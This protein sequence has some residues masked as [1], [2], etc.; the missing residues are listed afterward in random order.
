MAFIAA[1]NMPVCKYLRGSLV[2]CIPHEYIGGA[3]WTFKYAHAINYP[4][5]RMVE[6]SLTL[7]LNYFM[8]ITSAELLINARKLDFWPECIYKSYYLPM[9]KR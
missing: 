7:L 4:E 9:I 8:L 1:D 2:L 5:Q 6:V 3:N